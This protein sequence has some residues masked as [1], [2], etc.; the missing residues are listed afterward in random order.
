MKN[1]ILHLIFRYGPGIW[2]PQFILRLFG[3]PRLFNF[4]KIYQP[5]PTIKTPRSMGTEEY[6]K[7]FLCTIPI[8]SERIKIFSS[9]KGIAL[10]H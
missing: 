3:P 10:W 7:S 2:I 9:E 8:A 6:V 1:I 4:R 5:P